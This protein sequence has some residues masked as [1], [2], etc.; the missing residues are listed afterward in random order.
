MTNAT[1][2]TAKRQPWMKFY[3]TDWQAD[4]ELGAC[5]LTARGLWIELISLMHR[6]EKYGFLLIS[7][8]LPTP[9]ALSLLTR[10]DLKTFNS[11]VKNWR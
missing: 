7:G 9:R 4:G 8:R 6:S 10:C 3:P 1:T 2:A 11:A 5:S